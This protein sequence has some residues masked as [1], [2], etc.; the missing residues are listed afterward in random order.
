M[1]QVILSQ[2]IRF[3]DNVSVILST[4]MHDAKRRTF[5]WLSLGHTNAH[6]FQITP[7]QIFQIGTFRHFPECFKPT[8]I[9]L[10]DQWCEIETLFERLKWFKTPHGT[11]NLR[12]LR[13]V[14]WN[15]HSSVLYNTIKCL[16]QNCHTCWHLWLT[17]FIRHICWHLLRSVNLLTFIAKCRF[18]DT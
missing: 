11:Q 9:S 6:L 17:I 5:L 10:L 16:F 3:W 1:S 18:I 8:I 7:T 2:N 15:C 14:C 4:G 13:T 12:L